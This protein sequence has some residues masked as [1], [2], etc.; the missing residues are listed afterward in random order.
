MS[1]TDQ[2]VFVNISFYYIVINLADL[3][4]YFVLAPIWKIPQFELQKNIWSRIHLNVMWRLMDHV[5]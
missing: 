5:K 4:E 3:L 2:M 1:E